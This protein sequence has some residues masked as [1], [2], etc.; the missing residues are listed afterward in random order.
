MQGTGTLQGDWAVFSSSAA[1]S[2]CVPPG[3]RPAAALGFSFPLWEAAVAGSA[4]TAPLG[5]PVWKCNIQDVTEQGK[6]KA[7]ISTGRTEP[8]RG[9]EENS[10][11]PPMA[12]GLPPRATASNAVCRG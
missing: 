4:W 3:T 11:S 1:G 12:A 7:D 6:P 9:K 2:L 5:L 10:P 8:R